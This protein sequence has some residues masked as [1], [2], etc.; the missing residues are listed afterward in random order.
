MGVLLRIFGWPHELL[1]ALALILIGRR[2]ERVE[3]D[4]IDIPGDLSTG[5]FV[6]VAGFPALLFLI[7]GAICVGS[8]SRAADAGQIM[9]WLLLTLVSGIAFAGTV[10]DLLLIFG[11]LMLDTIPEAGVAEE[12]EP[13]SQ[14]KKHHDMDRQSDDRG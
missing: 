1:H 7:V 9:L 5:Q 8:L 11:R 3:Q 10:G 4:H 6:F 13:Q 12:D 14:I 2:P